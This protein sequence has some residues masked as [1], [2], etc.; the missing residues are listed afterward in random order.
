MGIALE[1]QFNNGNTLIVMEVGKSEESA[2]LIYVEL[3]ENDQ[4]LAEGVMPYA[5]SFD[6][7]LIGY[8]ILDMEEQGV[9][10][11]EKQ[12]ENSE[13]TVNSVTIFPTQ[14]NVE[15]GLLEMP[16]GYSIPVNNFF[17][18]KEKMGAVYFKDRQIRILTWEN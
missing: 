8:I 6:D 12:R 11:E 2:A 18:V 7:P 9:L 16:E 13:G 3:D 14:A 4:L 1:Q 5:K 17:W 10:L 15:T